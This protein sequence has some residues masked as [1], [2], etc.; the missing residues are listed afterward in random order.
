[1]TLKLEEHLRPIQWENTKKDWKL[2]AVYQV[3]VLR[4][5]RVLL[6][7]KS[8]C[9]QLYLKRFIWISLK[10]FWENT[11]VVCSSKKIS[12]YLAFS[13]CLCSSDLWNRC[14]LHLFIKLNSESCAFFLV[15]LKRSVWLVC[16]RMV[17]YS[18]GRICNECMNLSSHK[19][20]KCL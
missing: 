15:F 8:Y 16:R 1:M 4:N 13:R 9:E 7:Y 3:A 20:M 19:I 6:Q 14:E 2:G 11:F 5:D 10:G 17:V 18:C 12:V